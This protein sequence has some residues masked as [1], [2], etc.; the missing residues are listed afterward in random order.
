[1]PTISAA[2]VPGC[3]VR[4]AAVEP[5][6]PAERL[7]IR[8]GDRLVRLNTHLVEDVLDYHFH[9][10]ARRL[11]VEWKSAQA[12]AATTHSATVVKEY[13]ESLGLELEPFETRKC[14]NRCLFCFVHQLPRGLRRELYLK[15][16][17]YRLS[18]LHGSYITGTNLSPS[19][20]ERIARMRLSPLYVS[21]H[22]TDEAI[23]RRLLGHDSIEPILPLLSWLV[24]KHIQIHAQIVLCPGINDG[25]VL[26]RT[27]EDLGNLHPGLDSVAVVP[28]GLTAHRTGLPQ[29]Q[30]VTPEMAARVLR[31]LDT[32]R[33]RMRRRLGTPLVH[34]SD[35]FYLLAGL[36]PPRMAHDEESPQ[37]ANGVGMIARFFS[38]LDD[39]VADM[40]EAL[41]RR[42]NE[43]VTLLTTV[44]GPRY[45]DRLVDAVRSAGGPALAI[46]PVENSL[47][48]AQ[49]T[50]SGLLP[51][52]D[53]G[54]AVLANQGADR[55]LIPSN[56][57]RPWD[58]RFIDG[59]TLKDIRKATGADIVAGGE[60]AGEALRA[61]FG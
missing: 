11:R 56:A 41:R 42:R 35:E 8:V 28:V 53:F 18:F 52:R 26:D 5:G 57:L 6:S 38:D 51:A 36:R 55:Y 45:L 19:D 40:C 13:D 32:I 58:H 49:V 61:A 25:P 48:G 14:S 3:G 39:T 54:A 37:L 7:G 1:M 46:V 60:T 29:L 21:V 24:R 15:D 43:R 20:K 31:S 27:I 10:T 30:A 50:V 12:T 4:I 17:D 47:F 59:P 2:D 44:M 16:E 23:R 22:A 9:A 33:R 34:A